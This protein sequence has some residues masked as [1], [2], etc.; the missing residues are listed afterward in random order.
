VWPT[1]PPSQDGAG[2]RRDGWVTGPLAS[3]PACPP[4]PEFTDFERKALDVIAECFGSDADK[5][6]RQVDASEV[7]D[8]IN[9]I[10]GFYTRVRADRSA[11]EPL[12]ITDSGGHFEVADIEHG[13]GVIL[14]GEDGYLDQIEGFGYGADVFAGKDLSKLKFVSGRPG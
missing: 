8:R 6:L 10:H 14:W 11:C 9:T 13:V 12:P 4:F 2:R 7:I 5:F 3:L 1:R